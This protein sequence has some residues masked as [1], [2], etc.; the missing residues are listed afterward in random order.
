MI[1][2]FYTLLL[3]VGVVLCF[4]TCDLVNPE[5]SIP[6]YIYVPDFQLTTTAGQ[7]T[8]SNK[9]TDVWLSVNGNFLGVYTLPALI[10]ILAEGEQTI[11]LEAGIKDNGINATPEIYP[12]YKPFEIKRNLKPNVVDTIRPVTT[13]RDNARFSFIEPFEQESHLFQDLRTG[14]NFNRIQITREGAF[15]GNAAWI[16]MDTNNPILE[17]ATNIRFEDLKAK[18]GLVYLEVN[19]KSE[20]PV[21][22]GL[23]GYPEGAATGVPLYDPGFLPSNEW[24]KIYFNL[25]S[26]LIGSIY[27]EFQIAFQ[28]VLPNQNGVFTQNSASIWLDNIKLVRF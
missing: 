21:I 14:N 19:Y 16:R 22:F 6:A 25:S 13:Y 12:F 1:K 27:S 9:I 17:L 20:V 28:S 2:K 8:N 4:S 15:E 11:I 10:P 24:N 7:G 18:G 26:L 5:E 23:I 3:A